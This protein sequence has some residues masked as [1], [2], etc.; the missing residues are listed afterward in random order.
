MRRTLFAVAALGLIAVLVAGALDDRERAF[1][2]GQP[3]VRIAAELSPGERACHRGID[4]PA[5]FS[6]VRLATASFRRTGPALTVTAGDAL[7]TVP[8]G[9]PDNSTVEARVAGIS[10]GDRIDVCVRND[11]DRRVA[12]YGSPPD[13]PPDDL[14]DPE[15]VPEI[16]ITFVREPR[17]MLALVPDTF[18]RA[19]LFRPAWVGA[20]TFWLLLG[21]VCVGVPLLLAAAYR[22]AVT[23]SASTS[24]ADAAESKR[25]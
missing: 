18:E 7:G 3:P 13:T 14:G 6:L 23:D 5:S 17:S 8:A 4:V 22:S 15:L 16:G 2:V 10:E 25:S 9:Y 1:A 19:A 20:W 21:L 12:L 24:A 11:G